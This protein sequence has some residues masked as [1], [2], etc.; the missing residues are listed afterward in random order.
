MCI[1]ILITIVKTILLQLCTADDDNSTTTTTTTN[2]H[3]TFTIRNLAVDI[4]Y[5]EGKPFEEQV[6]FFRNTDI[7]ISPH[8]AGL[9]GLVFMAG[10]GGGGS[11]GHDDSDD[12]GNNS[13]KEV[14]ELYPKN[15]AIPYY[16]GSLAIQSGI[17]HSYVY[18]DD[19][20]I[21]KVTLQDEEENN[22][23][24]I[25]SNSTNS[26][27][28]TTSDRGTTATTTT[29]S[30]LLSYSTTA[31]TEKEEGPSPLKQVM[32]W[33]RVSAND[34]H[35][36][37]DAR[38]AKFCP[39]TNDMNNMVIELIKDWY[40]CRHRNRNRN[41]NRDDHSGQHEQSTSR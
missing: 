34:Y 9:T 23:S 7:L 29:N 8:G 20:I 18:Y 13:C 21:E 25:T 2:D 36:R 30:S 33:E 22:K 32:P 6:Q 31:Q 3:S 12:D 4:T 16:F 28:S 39:R 38:S 40:K 1:M 5:F 14:M 10:G 24:I 19:G 15:Y 27:I 11:S 26:T 37:R 17:R 35:T 41:R